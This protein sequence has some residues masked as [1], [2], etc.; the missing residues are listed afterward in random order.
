MTATY[1]S[2]SYL[3]L[4]FEGGREDIAAP[5]GMTLQQVLDL[6][7]VPADL[8]PYTPSGERL[9]GGLVIGREISNGSLIV[10]YSQPYAPK[11]SITRI[12]DKKT[13]LRI[14]FSPYVLTTG[15]TVCILAALWTLLGRLLLGDA[16][17]L[18][19]PSMALVLAGLA[20]VLGLIFALLPGHGRPVLE[21]GA[22]LACGAASGVLT[23]L[24]NPDDY[25]YQALIGAAA[26]AGLLS[27]VRWAWRGRENAGTAQAT[28][29]GA[30]FSLSLAVIALAALFAGVDISL[31]AA[32]LFGLSA[33][34]L[35]ALPGFSVSVDQAQLIN[36]AKIVREASSVR[37]AEPKAPDPIT[38]NFIDAVVAAGVARNRLWTILICTAVLVCFPSVASHVGDSSWRG[39][40]AAG[41]IVCVILALLLVPRTAAALHVRL[42]PRAT[43]GILIL[44]ATA[45]LGSSSTAD[46]TL[47]AALVIGTA[48]L[49]IAVV[50]IP[51]F[52][53]WHALIFTRI[54][55]LLQG[56]A[57]TF[58]LPLSLAGAGLITLIRTGGLG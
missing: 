17:V 20:F 34:L 50:S 52:R 45:A 29:D 4:A 27:A 37:G 8:I 35:L 40:V 10:L 23:T 47:V 7:R 1:A 2:V 54:G 16:A 33:P 31:L 11:L 14:A 46:V 12:P 24:S 26:A 25:A 53:S 5:F 56:F 15:I 43:A 58:A 49:L 3:T 19:S 42:L 13:S 39:P 44:A 6:R 32:A 36:E 55:D 57:C 51:I 9:P 41:G 48:A 30:V 22:P 21:T 38:P 28:A 18:T